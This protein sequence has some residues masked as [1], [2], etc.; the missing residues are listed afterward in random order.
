MKK[1]FLTF[2]LTITTMLMVIFGLTA[3]GEKV[4]NFNLSF[5]VNGETYQT[6]TTTGNESITIPENPAKTGY[7]FD[8]WYWD[9][10]VWN[11][12]FTA[13]SLLDVPISSDMSVYAKFSAIKYD[14]TYKNDGGTHSNPVSY[15]IE[16]SFVLSAA[17][18]L[19][20]SFVG[21]YS[22]SAYTTKVESVSAGSTGAITLYAKFEIENY[23]ISYTNT[24]E[25]VN[26][27]P[28]TYNVETDTIVLADL[29]K[30]GYTFEG[31]YNGEEE[32]TEIAKGS[33][34]DLTVEAKWT[35]VEYEV[36]YHNVNG[37]INSNPENYNVDEQPLVLVDLEKAGYN[38]LGW[39]TDE[40]FT[41]EITEISVG[42]TG[43]INLYAKWEIIEY[44]ATFMD[45]TTVVK[46]VKFTVETESIKEPAVPVHIGYN[47]EWEEYIL[48]AKNITIDAVY[49]AIEY[50]AT[51][52][53]GT[54]VVEE[55]K[56]TVETESID[57]PAVPSHTGYIGEW[58]D[59]TLV[60]ED[61]TIDAVYTAIE[62]TATFMDGTTVVEEIKFTVETETIDEPAVPNHVGY[63]GEWEAYTLEAKNITIDA[64]YTI[65]TYNIEYL[66]TKDVE[67]ENP[68]IYTIESET[69]ILENLSKVG[70]NF[71]GWY[72]NAGNKVEKIE[73]DG[74]GDLT[75]TA[76]WTTLTYTIT[77]LY[78]N[79]YGDLEEGKT[80]KASYT[81]EDEFAFEELVCK[82]EGFNFRGWFTEKNVGTG[83]KVSGVTKGTTGNFTVY[84]QFGL[85]VYDIT[86]INVNGAINNNPT[87]Y[88]VET[89]DFTIYPLSKEGYNFDGWF[90]NEECTD[91]ATLT[92][93]KGSNGDIT[94]Y[95]K[96]TAITYTIEYVTYG[97][98]FENNNYPKTYT[99]NNEI[100]LVEPTLS[101]NFFVG[102]FT[103]A[104]GG[105]LQEKIEKGSTGNVTLYARWVS[106][107]SNGGSK[108]EYEVSIEKDKF[109]EPVKINQPVAPEKDYYTFEGWYTN[110]ELTNKFNFAIPSKNLVLYANW[111]ATEY[112]INYVLNGGENAKENQET[113]T[114]EDHVTFADASK[115]GYTFVGWF[116][117]DEFT[118][119][120]VEELPLGSHG[121]ITL[122]AHYLINKYTISFETNGGTSVTAITQNYA[123]EVAAPEAPAKNGYEFVGWYAN[124]ELT[125]KYTFS[126]MPAEDITLYAK[127]NIVTYDI[128]YNLDGGKFEDSTYAKTYKIDSENITLKTPTKLGY[129][130]A[131]WYIDVD[132]ISKIETIIKG[133]YGDLEL[134]AKWTAIEYTITYVMPDGTINN[135]AT[136][137]T[138]ETDLTTLTNA[139]VK[140]YDFIGWFTDENY[141]TAITTIGGGETGNKAIYGKFNPATYNVWLDGNEE[142]KCVVSFNLNGADG[143]IADQAITPTAVLKY[144]TNPTREGY[145]FGGWYDNEDCEGALYDFTAVVTSDTILYA[146]W[147]KIENATAIAI[148]G[149]A[150][151]TLNGKTEQM[152]MFVP[153]VS[154]NIIITASGSCDTFGVL[155]N[156]DMIALIQD[157]D[158]AFDGINFHIVYNVTAGKVYYIGARA[159]SSTT[160]GS[161]TVSISG[162]TTV[163]DGGYTITASKDTVTYGSHFT[164][165]LPEA[166]EGYK[167][168]GYADD[169]V[170]Y[171]D[172]TGASVKVWDKDQDTTLYSV[173]EKMIY[174]VT[175]ETSGGSPIESVELAFGERLDI[176]QYVTTRTGYT[177]NGWYY[178]GTEYNATTMPDYN[179]TLT[180]YWKT[181]ALGTIK[182]DTDKKAVSVNDEITAELFDAICL[183]ANSNLATF[184]VVISG[185]QE[186][187]ETISV[188]L[189]ATSGNKTKQVTI[190]DV[191]VYGMPTLTFDNTVDYVNVNGGLTASAFSASGTDTFG[192][193]TKI[194]VYIDGE[195]Q[196][197]QLVTVTIASIDLAGNTVYGYVENVKAYGLPEIT[198]NQ[199]KTSIS[200]NDTL[201]AELFNATA[202][203]SFGESVAVTVTR[204]SGTISA[205]NTVT[206]RLS[207]TDSK[208]NV[209]NIDVE[210]KVYGAP[211]ISNSTVSEIKLSDDITVELLDIS[212]I[213]TY[214]EN[215]DIT[216]IYDEKV[217]GEI[218]TVTAKVTDIAGNV[219]T[220]DFGL[221]VY[222]TPTIT[223]DKK[224]AIKVTEDVTLILPITVGFNLNGGSGNIKT[225]TITAT[226]GI[227]YPSTIPTREGYAFTGWYTTKDCTDLYDFT[228]A[229]VND[230][231]LYAG[232]EAMI[233]NGYWGRT[234]IDIYNNY[235]SSSKPLSF[236]TSYTSSSSCRYTYFTALDD[237]RYTLYYRNSSSNS[238]Y[239]TYIYVYNA[240]QGTVIKSNTKINSTSFTSSAS[241]VTFSANAG[242]V[243]YVRNY[244][245][246]SDATFYMYVAGSSKPAAGGLSEKTGANSILNAVAK[247]SFGNELKVVASIKEGDLK[248]G[249]IVTYNLTATDHLG[250]TFTIPTEAIAVYDINDIKLTYL[251]GMSDLIKLSSKGEEFDAK[252]TDSFGNA[253]DISIEPAEGYTLAGGNIISLYIVAT[254]KAGNKVYSDLIENIKVYD[255]P[256]YKVNDIL[257][258]DTDINFFITVKD[259]FGEELYANVQFEGKL[260]AWEN[261]DVTINA[262]DD[263]E[264]IL[265]IKLTLLVCETGFEAERQGEDIVL[266]KYLGANSEVIVPNAI[267]KI[268][269]TAFVNNTLVENVFIPD[270]VL[271]IEKGVF[272][273]C[274]SL[275]KLTIP[276]V[277]AKA[278]VTS[279]D[280]YQYPFGYIF[281]ESSYTGGTSTR[282]YYYGSSMSSTTSSTYYIS[283]SLKSVTVTG[284][285]IL[286]GAFY[287]CSSLTSV[288]I[289]DSVTSIGDDTF[290]NCSGLTS[291]TIPDNVTSIGSS[292]FNNCS[293]LT[294][295]TIP[296][297]VTSIGDDTFRNCSGL[298]SVVIG[299][300][301]ESI[302]SYAIYNCS[303]LTSVTLPDSV[304]S[305]G[306][307]AFYNC[308]SLTSVVIPDSVTSIG[309][310][311]FYNCISLTKLYITNI[312][313]WCNISFGNYYANPLCYASKLYLNSE[314]V[315]ELV[316]IP[317]SVISIASYAFYN[318]SGLTSVV[319][320]DGVESIGA[321][322]FSGCSSLTRVVIGDGVASIGNSTFYNCSSLTSMVIGDGIE[323]IGADAFSGCS[324]LTSV[325][326]PDSVI[327]I[328]SYAFYNCS[329]LTSVVIG[330]G[331]E[332]IGA[333]AF[334]GCSSLTE[335][336]LPFVGASK[337]GTS[338]THFGYI[339]GASSYSSNSSYVPTSL[340]KVTI[341]GGA[342]DSYAF[343][344]C[345]SLT[346]VVIPDS[347]T[348]ISDY[349]FNN[350]SS[351]TSI[352]IPK[353]VTS[354][355]SSAFNNC[356][357]LTSI[358]IPE[359]VTSIGSSAFSACSILTEMTLPFV[360]A[361]KDGQ[362]DTHFGYIFGASEYF[363]NSSYVPTSLKKVT[364]MG[365]AIDS[366]AFYNCSSLTSV[367]VGDGV[368]SIG[369]SAFRNCSSLTEMTLPFV[370]ATK[371]GI[372]KKH[373]GYI[374][375]A[376]DFSSNSSYVPTSLKKVTIMGGA[377]DSYAFNN[378]SSL[379]SVVIP[380]SVTSI[381]D[382]AFYNC[383]GLTSVTIPD[384]VTSISD[385]AFNN[386]SSLTSIAI[387]ESVT[388]IGSYAFYDCSSLTSV[389]I[390]DGVTSISRSTFRGCSSLTSVTIPDGV[391]SIG[392]YAFAYCSDLRNVTLPNSVTSI[393]DNAFVDCGLL[394]ITIPD[395]VTSIGDSAF[396]SC[397]F[398]REITLPFVGATKGGTSNTHFGYIFGASSYSE[399][400]NYLQLTSLKKVTI[401]GG[402]I[403]SYAFHTLRGLTSVVI[404]DNVMRIGDSAFYDCGGLTSVIIGDSVTSIASSAFY[405]CI[406]LTSVIIG[407]SV[408]SIGSYAFYA[409]ESLTNVAIPNSV[410][411]IGHSAFYY[412]SSLTEMTL[413]FVGA[414]KDGI[415][416]THLGYIFGASS[417]SS[418]SS[419][420]PASLKKVL[421]MS[422]ANIGDYAFYDCGGLTSVIIGDSVTSIG[423]S[424][425][426]NC[427]SL[428]SIA[429]PESVTSIGSYAFSKCSSL[430][431]VTIPDSVTSIGDFA[432]R[433][434]TNLASLE[435]GNSVTSIGDFAFSG[436]SSLTSVTIPDSVTSIGDSAFSG[437]SSLQYKIE[438]NCKYLGCTENPYVYL[439]GTV[440][441]NITTVTIN[442]NCK[443]I[444]P[445]AFANCLSLTSVVVPNSVI[446]VGNYGFA[447]CGGLKEITLPFVGANKAAISYQSVFGYIF[448][449]ETT[450]SA[451][452]V[453]G[454][455]YQYNNGNTYYHYYIPTSL[456]KV[457]ITGGAI[458]SDAFS[459]C[460][461][462]TSIVIS[463]GVT[464][465]GDY[466]FRSC[467][468]LTSVVIPDSV[469][470]IGDFAFYNCS[471][472]TS[473]VIPDSVTSIGSYAF[474]KCSSLKSVVIPDSV[475]SI[476]YGAFGNCSSLTS[477]TF[478]DTSTWYLTTDYT[479]WEDKTGGTSTSVT[480]SSTNATYFKSTYYNYYWYKL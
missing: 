158:T 424:A 370:G 241:Y 97:G 185:K 190:S 257:Y 468:S 234:Y 90:S 5:K 356:S 216:F 378:C 132:R 168:L 196:V 124:E 390:P 51:F 102:W 379:T 66:N 209:T 92:I 50:T 418:N 470:N 317:D 215:L 315:T 120:V 203:D 473:V 224:D 429:I 113:Y 350:C 55:V 319:I 396:K 339:F 24:K 365:G 251:A 432:F 433:G 474:G 179:I 289:P 260:I 300:G 48:E 235:N 6:I 174:T 217:A 198:Y 8:G 434:C 362:S 86:Y 223:Y 445:Y 194:E 233:T 451:S 312:V 73:K 244:K 148:N 78:D 255:I 415:N 157:D 368:E 197:G 106:F 166:R 141:T 188:R 71:E 276:F 183:D 136:I 112:K 239:G 160:T 422:A 171:T 408:T 400:S 265:D 318:C 213:D 161:V 293:S 56:F 262:T 295:V 195:Y 448:G 79:A 479:N 436:C 178:N 353:S 170:M 345:S 70:Y 426:Y 456:K 74:Y 52:M 2:I 459:M 41:N 177:F 250:N 75:L 121:E 359:S 267:T 275:A 127:W 23:T 476:G 98:A 167:F 270:S 9:K 42:T 263:A 101:N 200:V 143:N 68:E 21:W 109:N 64:V 326:I 443:F 228:T 393:D 125:R 333:Y 63:N 37:T 84:A 288:T 271:E 302:G 475:T 226:E 211:T 111:E 248:A 104:E 460:S 218:L 249:S 154:G 165:K 100:S 381:G 466:A 442:Q 242:D 221:K 96:W 367:V 388:S 131:G 25:V 457:K 322:A 299:D 283:T 159:F 403:Y 337:G 407:D 82:N 391:T 140:G 39:F 440:S 423:D 208:G 155:Y 354:I 229:I 115:T 301:V 277:G 297:S 282:Q 238:S 164:L 135:N 344:N 11:K 1:R 256:T 212:A 306:A 316:I 480:N 346:S 46:E 246:S 305:I 296:N 320:G 376:S 360:G 91:E 328:A 240:T 382:H 375:G 421:I 16:D 169:G 225:Q 32:I 87:Y 419:Y 44:T 461:S 176:G 304:T 27:N 406:N 117:D 372:S 114:V 377:I 26:N 60:T 40:N 204:Y 361:T 88:D 458:N 12:P 15:T 38:F 31:W 59:Y 116:T 463:D 462:L 57:E 253:C 201:S 307:S 331:V 214:G 53:D 347:V 266:K 338:N 383:S 147:V 186:A 455:T 30:D 303:S 358:A 10:D 62:Y 469:T 274:S 478:K 3:C 81:V 441:T 363:S 139:S 292:A 180:A 61:I 184:S 411:S 467:S 144:P 285:N 273:G 287:N 103:L 272:S 20:Y 410:T 464:S 181:F 222:G 477:I 189:V 402:T 99:I 227:T 427:S 291:V 453:S 118:S 150:S 33:T 261:V 89:D 151:I 36:I 119:T 110:G 34:G 122:Y 142:A 397:S 401:T 351:L 343:C 182:Y 398:L 308:S 268:A 13:N 258:E 450:S 349:A 219:I 138:I 446:S 264:N 187:G 162:N 17:E 438:N 108:V 380:D 329:G 437:C 342:I 129:N 146:K 145:I 392:E 298:T 409:C 72:N 311:A 366:Y 18:K 76:R 210:C 321:Y 281:G 355:G 294:S 28:T 405:R 472:L 310:S 149:S 80:L 153:L 425:F 394:S 330:D 58:E 387:P 232:W 444:A 357:R 449:Y 175:F 193:A 447:N 465:I 431:S 95:A 435:I 341:M 413:P 47:G 252:A 323:S 173:W 191:K 416:N 439:A 280:S 236:S 340:K 137:Y 286:Y 130:F 83:D 231:T 334:S 85:E 335:M 93:A 471:S 67:S 45:G 35:A 412:C 374:F 384:G 454:A 133:S 420:V 324:S 243:I 386:C 414:M 220:K 163:L 369:S 205:G 279:N 385:Y 107:E 172:S 417:Y 43:E 352:A 14:I 284:G 202:K 29:S 404:G 313:A 373:F 7:K 364:I 22:D 278:G 230:I 269:N 206:I 134:F 332:S 49:T 399:Q 123:T 259:S 395:S 77:Y 428:T 4:D 19:G 54:T 237:G 199:N 245:Y 290:R 128:V 156:A 452:A 336:T 314:L 389:T 65:I 207:T 371:D 309:A 94:L 192:Q 105:K 254:D 327:S 430:K 325:T 152:L 69:I 126:T 348:S 247:D